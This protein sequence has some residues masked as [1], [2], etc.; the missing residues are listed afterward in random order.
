MTRIYIY[1]QAKYVQWTRGPKSAMSPSAAI[2]AISPH[3]GQ[4]I[5]VLGDKAA[6]RAEKHGEVGNHVGA[7]Q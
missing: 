2:W 1:I 4:C 5:A 3:V 6:E 7:K